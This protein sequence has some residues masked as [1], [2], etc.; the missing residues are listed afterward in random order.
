LISPDRH[1]HDDGVVIEDDSLFLYAISV[2]FE[3]RQRGAESGEVLEPRKIA[4]IP[5]S[6]TSVDRYARASRVHGLPPT[7][8][9]RGA[10]GHSGGADV[11]AFFLSS[12]H[13]EAMPPVAG[14][15]AAQASFTEALWSE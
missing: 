3:Y 4:S 10:T 11:P 12:A 13:G 9:V 15:F 1:P 14:S 8:S 2:A 7:G 5:Q 6:P